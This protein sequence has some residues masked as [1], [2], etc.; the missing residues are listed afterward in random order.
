MTTPPPPSPVAVAGATGEVG[1]GA[2][3]ALAG[4]VPLRL[5][6]RDAARTRAAAEA[7]RGG[8]AASG[9]EVGWDTARYGD[10]G[11]AER[12][13]RGAGVLLMVS[14]A[15]TAGRLDEHRTF[16][17]AAARAGVRHVVYTSFFGAAPD[18]VFTLAR[19]HFH[20]EEHLKASGMGWTILRDNF[21]QDVFPLFVGEDGA[22]RGPAGTGRVSAVARDDVAACAAVVLLDTAAALAAGRAAAHAGR[23]YALTGPEAFTLAEAAAEIAA[24][25]GRPAVF[26][27][28]TTAEAYASRAAYGAPPWQ[29]DAWVST[30]TAIA[31]GD[32]AEVTGDVATLLGRPARPLARTLGLLPGGPARR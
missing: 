28:E 16:I 30:Y 17:D 20:T 6:G 31:S 15:E 32:L 25:T 8:A 1:S 22:L 5:L 29:V 21:Y 14:A 27:D 7:L 10:A 19:D 26:R 3:R 2:A 23:T 12:A 24:A 9:H 13:L 4:R 11:A 18:A